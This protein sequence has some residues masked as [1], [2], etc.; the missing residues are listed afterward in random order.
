MNVN[1]ADIIPNRAKKYIAPY[2]WVYQSYRA[3]REYNDPDISMDRR[4]TDHDHI[5]LIVVDALRGD[6]IPDLPLDFT[7]GVAAGTW[8]FP[9]VTSMHTGERPSTHKATAHTMPGDDV[10]AM[11]QQ[12]DSDSILTKYLDASGF[13]TYAGC[14]FPTPFLALRGWYQSHRVYDDAP[15]EVVIND[16]RQWRRSRSTTFSYLHLGDLH[17]P[18]DPPNEY[19]QKYDVDLS[20]PDL[21]NIGYYNNNYSPENSDCIDYRENKL[22]LYQAA[23]DYVSDQLRPLIQD[24]SENTQIFLVG[25]HGESLWEY[26]ELDQ[27]MSDS[28]P[29]YCLG[30][31]GTPF[32]SLARVPIGTSELAPTPNGGW[33]STRDLASTIV[34]SN[35]KAQIEHPGRDWHREIPRERSVICESTRYGPERKAIYR[36]NL[37]LIKSVADG[38]TLTAKVSD[39]GETFE[40]MSEETVTSLERSLPDEWDGAEEVGHTS[41]IVKDRLENLGYK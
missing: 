11:P 29:N 22:Q 14:A 8:T 27:A 37:K 39:C 13:H 6:H 26:A 12:T 35:V 20:L 16:Y 9:S 1:L 24:I 34:N 5:L 40:D 28:R 31:G 2:Y 25:D 15:A 7:T 3:D 33:P 36:D 23:L 10:Y 41:N 21:P 32:D 4:E 18:V 30:H 17:A 38:V 19:I